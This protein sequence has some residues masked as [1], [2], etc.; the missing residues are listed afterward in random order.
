LKVEAQNETRDTQP[1]QHLTN[2]G[3]LNLLRGADKNKTVPRIIEK[4]ILRSTFSV[5]KYGAATLKIRNKKMIT[6][7]FVGQ[8][9]LHFN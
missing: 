3:C 9:S 1:A 2:A 5:S 4:I 8:Y 6:N 7:R